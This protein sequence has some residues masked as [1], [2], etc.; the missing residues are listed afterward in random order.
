MRA[1]RA[2]MPQLIQSGYSVDHRVSLGNGR[3]GLCCTVFSAP[4][5]PQWQ[6]SS[7][8][9]N[10]ASFITLLQNILA[11]QA[12]EKDKA[13]R[14]GNDDVCEGDR[15]KNKNDTKDNERKDNDDSND[16]DDQWEDVDKDGADGADDADDNCE[17]DE[18]NDDDNDNDR[19]GQISGKSTAVEPIV[20]T[21]DAVHPRADSIPYYHYAEKDTQHSAILAALTKQSTSSK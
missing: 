9:A 6:V 10:K 18:D 12:G 2:H 5:Y 19:D 17:D 20:T 13:S 4:D 3:S 14:K 21:F 7:R 11:V 8:F 15:R 1:V 16:D